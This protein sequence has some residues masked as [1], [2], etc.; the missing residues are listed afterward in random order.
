M[1]AAAVGSVVMMA[2]TQM[3][4]SMNLSVRGSRTMA[5]RD[6]LSMRI[7]REAGNPISLKKSVEFVGG[8][9]FPA[10][11]PGSMMDNCA[12]GTVP[13]GCVAKDSTTH[14]PIS[15]GFTLTD[16]FSNPIAGP[17]TTTA[18]VY[19]INGALCGNVSASAPTS[20]CPIVVT[21]TF[22]PN[23]ANSQDS[24]DRAV[25]MDVHYSVSQAS[26]VQLNGGSVLKT[27]TGNVST[28]IPFA[29][30][31]NGV[32]NMLA[33]WVSNT[34]LSSSSVY[35]SSTGLVGIG[36]ASPSGILEV[37]GGT[38]SASTDGRNIIFNAQNAGSGNQN[39]GSIILNSG[40]SSGTGSSGTVVVG[41]ASVPTW[42]AAN[43]LFVQNHIYAASIDLTNSNNGIADYG[44]G[45]NTSRVSGSVPAGW[46]GI[47][48][49]DLERLHID[50][51]GNITLGT[52][53]NP[54]P[55]FQV[56]T[57]GDG[58]V[59]IANAW[60]T[61]SD[62]RLK[63][64]LKRISNAGELVDHLNGYYYSWKNKKDRSRQVGVIAQEVEKVLPELVSTDA[65][66]FK[67]VDYPKL[68][69]VLIEASKQLH[70]ELEGKETEIDSLQRQNA[71]IMARLVKVEKALNKK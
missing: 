7:S 19:D 39:G 43:S 21:S 42:A 55:K 6:Q 66:G 9:G 17:S 65:D 2:L 31:V 62:I 24:C 44:F 40:A 69:A 34:E 14:N 46:V 47:F 27:Q 54:I 37:Q 49:R 18:A 52:A 59:A 10:N 4:T 33:K 51:A 11:G 20:N 12:N 26:G 16:S 71:E 38:A 5:S 45:D 50:P 22:T 3:M 1:V 56:G 68:S 23:C 29:G 30:G 28:A 64:D 53:A 70:R 67:A 35:E 13:N 41:S 36:T 58:S 8:S 48:T 57:N 61:F 15:Y 25:S 60:N 32:V 63:K